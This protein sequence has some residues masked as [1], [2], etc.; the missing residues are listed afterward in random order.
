MPGRKTRSRRLFAECR[1]RMR[2]AEEAYRPILEEIESRLADTPA[3]P[4]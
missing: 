3:D 1:A 2:A 4:A